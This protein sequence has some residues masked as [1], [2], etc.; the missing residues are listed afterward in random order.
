MTLVSL[1]MPLDHVARARWL[2]RQLVGLYLSELVEELDSVQG[3][4]ATR[5]DNA[6]SDAPSLDAI[7]HDWL[8]EILRAGLSA[9]SSD[10]LRCLLSHPHCLID[11][12]DEIFRRGGPYWDSVVRSAEHTRA[13]ARVISG[14]EQ[15]IA[16]EGPS[17][18]GFK[19]ADST[20]ATTFPV[21][22]VSDASV[23]HRQSRRT[24]TWT[25]RA[26]LAAASLAAILALWQ[27]N[28]TDVTWGFNRPDVLAARDDPAQFFN[29]LADAAEDWFLE[30]PRDREPLIERLNQFSAGC[31]KLI[32][33][34]LETLSAEDRQWL[35]ER[36]GRWKT[37]I[38]GLSAQLAA[39]QSPPQTIRDAAD[40]I[41]RRLQVAL[42]ERSRG[43]A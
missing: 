39:G 4:R 2:E 9:L 8:D 33:S 32:E 38:D 27:L 5:G 12:Q 31:S 10:D 40:D 37:A 22:H 20:A 36:C 14:V 43:A 28:P 13:V 21:R 16:P 1:E 42:R 11:L 29:T 24:W 25:L 19:T 26:G 23:E 18:A 41:I 30:R 6:S 3:V 34:P 17:G 15:T 7:C 35:R